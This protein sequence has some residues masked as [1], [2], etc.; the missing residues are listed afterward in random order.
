MIPKTFLIKT[1]I[2]AFTIIFMKNATIKDQFNLGANSKEVG[3][4][5]FMD[6]LMD[7][8]LK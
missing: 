7:Y 4:Q 5:V 1:L 3:L 6:K 8:L 2:T